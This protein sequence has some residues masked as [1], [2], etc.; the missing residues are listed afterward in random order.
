M[1]GVVFTEFLELV[2]SIYSEDTVDDIIDDCELDHGGAYTSVGTYDYKELVALAQALSART[3][4]DLADLLQLFGKHMFARFHANYP[5]FFTGTHDD[6]HQL[7]SACRAQ[8][9]AGPSQPGPGRCG[10]PRPAWSRSR[11]ASLDEDRRGQLVEPDQSCEL[12]ACSMHP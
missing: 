12:R 10:L 3:G 11:R 1:K 4:T 6:Y 7:S 5:Q 8:W 9:G 2:S